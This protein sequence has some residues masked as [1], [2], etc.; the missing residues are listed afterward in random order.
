M[1][2]NKQQKALWAN[3]NN[4]FNVL[5]SVKAPVEVV[6]AEMAKWAEDF[7]S[8]VP[9]AKIKVILGDTPRLELI[10]C[11]RDSARTTRDAS[12]TT[13]L[14]AR[15]LNT[16]LTAVVGLRESSVSNEVLA[17]ALLQLSE[18]VRK[19]PF[20]LKDKETVDLFDVLGIRHAN[21]GD[22]DDD[23]THDSQETSVSPV[24]ASAEVTQG[25]LVAEDLV[26]DPAPAV[27]KQACDTVQEDCV[28]V[29]VS[30]DPAEVDQL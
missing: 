4:I 2:L 26:A 18:H 13:T 10:D 22:Q 11:S 1:N 16:R 3:V 17:D 24:E 14:R 25:A 12:M 28:L 7:E 6:T 8:Q 19:M 20:E 5:Q 21:S 15:I 29:L 30:A 27:E 23:L 9:D